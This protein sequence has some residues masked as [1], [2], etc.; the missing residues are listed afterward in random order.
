MAQQLSPHQE[1]LVSEALRSGAYQNPNEVIDRALETLH[2][3]DEWLMVN[4]QEI[5][6][7]IHRG[8]EELERGEGVPDDELDA[9]L[10][11]LKAQRE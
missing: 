7:K 8:I 5:D 6:S 10:A 11:R 9:Y 2:E 4:R 1:T 3:Q